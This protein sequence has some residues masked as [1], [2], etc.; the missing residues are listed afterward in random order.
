MP[1]KKEHDVDGASPPRHHHLWG[2]IKR[3]SR[4][5]VGEGLG[6]LLDRARRWQ[7]IHETERSDPRRKQ[8]TVAYQ[9]VAVR[10]LRDTLG[11]VDRLYGRAVQPIDG[12]IDELRSFVEWLHSNPDHWRDGLTASDVLELEAFAGRLRRLAET[13][14]PPP[15]ASPPT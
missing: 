2:R 12:D 3:A 13:V 1:D 5:A 10:A 11:R 9:R 7:A 6:L 4:A 14:S 15:T 8:A